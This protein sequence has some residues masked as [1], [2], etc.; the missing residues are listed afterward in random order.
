M[1]CNKTVLNQYWKLSH[2]LHALLHFSAKANQDCTKLDSAIEMLLE[3]KKRAK[4]EYALNR[5]VGYP[6]DLA[7]LGPV[8]RHVSNVCLS[9]LNH[10]YVV[11]QCITDTGEHRRVRAA[12]F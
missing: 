4:D 1:N 3:L 8:L 12:T 2:L 9:E 5:I 10:H 6:G 7:A 11:W